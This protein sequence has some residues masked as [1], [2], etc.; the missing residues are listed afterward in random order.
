VGWFSIDLDARS[1]ETRA[2]GTRA[3]VTTANATA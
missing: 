2:S 1:I 3:V